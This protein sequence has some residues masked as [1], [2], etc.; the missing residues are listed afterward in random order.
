MITQ[1]IFKADNKNYRSDNAKS[2]DQNQ[3]QI[4]LVLSDTRD[5]A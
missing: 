3:T 5:K 2:R 4:P 1:T